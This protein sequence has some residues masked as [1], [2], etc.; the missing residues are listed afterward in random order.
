MAE[1][2]GEPAPPP[3]LVFDLE[4][5]IASG[6]VAIGGDLSEENLLAAY[7]AGMYPCFHP[8]E[9]IL[10]WS[11][12]PRFILPL[13]RFRVPRSL[14]RTLDRGTFEVRCDTAFSEVIRGCAAAPRGPDNGVWIGEGMIAAYEQLARSGYAHSFEVFRNGHL[15]GGLYGVSLGSAF[16]GESMF[17][18]ERDASK[19]ALAGLVATLRSLDFD[20]L[21]CQVTT[22]HLARFGAVEVPKADFLARLE[23]ALSRPTLRGPWSIRGWPRAVRDLPLAVRHP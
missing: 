23:R 14:S 20:L 7:R 11:P 2:S 21:D 22:G 8:D 6:L 13:D 4:E 16:F 3:D 5:A 1:R 15:V 19:V 10:W 9:P 12:D 18:R 17:S